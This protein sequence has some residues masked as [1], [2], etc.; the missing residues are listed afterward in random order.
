ADGWEGLKKLAEKIGKKA[1]SKPALAEALDDAQQF[2][3]DEDALAA[4]RLQLKKLL[5]ADLALRAEAVAL[6]DLNLRH[7]ANLGNAQ[8]MWQ[9]ASEENRRFTS[10]DE[11]APSLGVEIRWSLIVTNLYNLSDA[12]EP[13]AIQ[14]QWVEYLPRDILLEM[15]AASRDN[16]WGERRA[17]TLAALA[18]RL[19]ELWPEVL[20][21]TEKFQ[22]KEARVQ[23]LIGLAKDIPVQFL[24]EVLA[25]AKMTV[26]ELEEA[27][28]VEAEDVEEGLGFSVFPALAERLP[29]E[30]F[31]QALAI[32]E[33][34]NNISARTSA[35]ADLSKRMPQELF[36]Q[37][38]NALQEIWAPEGVGI[39]LAAY[40]PRLPAEL[41]PQAVSI[42]RSIQSER[43]RA[44]ALTALAARLPELLPEA[45]TAARKIGDT[46]A[47]ARALI[48]LSEYLPEVLLEALAAAREITHEDS[49]AEALTALAPRLPPELLPEALAAAREIKNPYHCAEALTS[50]APHLPPELLPE[51]LAAAREIYHEYA[52]AQAL[53]ALAERLPELW[54]EVLAT[55]RDFP[56]T[57]DLLG[58]SPRAEA[59]TALAERLPEVVPEAL[60]AVREIYHEY[61]RAQTLTAL[62]PRLAALPRSAL[63][64][65]WAETLLVLT[66]RTRKDFLSDLRALVPLI[67]ALGG[68]QAVGETFRAIQDVSR[69]WP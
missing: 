61:A 12:Y 66:R 63:Y 43:A 69:W 25:I 5:R 49:S 27:D 37:V 62:A 8:S 68:E 54:P 30:L 11:A 3:N 59:L 15:L 40:A 1:E 31:P 50:L 17:E 57:A 48:A 33:K 53:T 9:R 21:L 22:D 20:S 13:R 51:A 18:K 60:A 32:A 14:H 52:R 26:D 24:P 46:G 34:I 38:L 47:R 67:H 41:L 45:L 42:A 39:L 29:S 4:L 10:Q 2:P 55:T 7:Y 56:E 64:P 44:Q 35:L 36:P 65:L 19:P 16:E 58:R 28:A 6:F 23:M